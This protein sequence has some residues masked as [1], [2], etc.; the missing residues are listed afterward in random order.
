VLFDRVL[1]AGLL[2]R[3]LLGRTLAL[4]LGLL[5]LFDDELLLLLLLLGLGP[6]RSIAITPGDDS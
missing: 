1:R 5:F 6:A 2:R 3:G 4:L